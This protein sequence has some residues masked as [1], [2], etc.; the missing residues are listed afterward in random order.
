[1]VDNSKA[2]WIITY[3]VEMPE[4]RLL[5]TDKV[6]CPKVPQGIELQ[7]FNWL[8]IKLRVSTVTHYTV[9]NV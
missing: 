5:K 6:K 3:I 1:M 4:F 7:P 2:L 8:L 9:N